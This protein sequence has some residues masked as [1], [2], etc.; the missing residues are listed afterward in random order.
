MLFHLR[1]S[2]ANWFVVLNTA[3]IVVIIGW[4]QIADYLTLSIIFVQLLDGL[5]AIEVHFIV[6]CVLLPLFLVQF[7][8]VLAIEQLGRTS[9][10]RRVELLSVRMMNMMLLIIEHYVLIDFTVILSQLCDLVSQYVSCA[11]LL[12]K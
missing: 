10:S 3:L 12:L 5:N 4:L 11:I 7:R 1:L 2:V 9:R 8:Q 6:R